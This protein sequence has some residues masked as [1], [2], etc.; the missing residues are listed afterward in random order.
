LSIRDWEKG[1]TWSQRHRVNRVWTETHGFGSVSAP[2][3][4]EFKVDYCKK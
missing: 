1:K 2:H 4:A 3:M